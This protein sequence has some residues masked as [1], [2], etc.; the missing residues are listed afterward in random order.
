MRLRE[1]ARWICT[2][3]ECRGEFVVSVSAK[4]EGA[5]NPRCCCG[6][7]MKQPYLQPILTT[8][9]ESEELGR[10]RHLL[11]QNKK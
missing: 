8:I 9:R 4:M 6:S 10:H 7:L 2:N 1:G 11:E 3:A 5:S